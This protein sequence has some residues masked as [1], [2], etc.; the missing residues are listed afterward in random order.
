[1]PKQA[2]RQ[3][4]GPRVQAIPSP[5]RR[6]AAFRPPYEAGPGGVNI[7]VSREWRRI[8]ASSV[9]L[10]RITGQS[11]LARRWAGL[12]FIAE[13]DVHLEAFSAEWPASFRLSV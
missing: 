7:E 8:T 6:G 1:M 5:T 3:V 12:D 10:S 4:A 11:T 2:M 9:I 13:R